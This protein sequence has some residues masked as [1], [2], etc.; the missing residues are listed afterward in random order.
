MPGSYTGFIGGLRGKLCCG[1]WGRCWGI[2]LRSCCC[3]WS[4]ISLC[5]WNILFIWACEEDCPGIWRNCCCCLCCCWRNSD[6]SECCWGSIF[7]WAML[8]I[9]WSCC[10]SNLTDDPRFLNIFCCCW[11]LET[12]PGSNLTG[13]TPPRTVGNCC[14]CCCCIECWACWKFWGSI[15]L[16]RCCSANNWLENWWPWTWPDELGETIEALKDDKP[17]NP[18]LD[19]GSD[20]APL[21]FTKE[22]LLRREEMFGAFP[23]ILILMLL[24][25]WGNAGCEGRGAPPVGTFSPL[26]TGFGASDGTILCICRKRRVTVWISI[27]SALCWSKGVSSAQWSRSVSNDKLQSRKTDEE[28]SWI[29]VVR[30][31]MEHSRA[32]GSRAELRNENPRSKWTKSAPFQLSTYNPKS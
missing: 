29:W 16:F 21:P 24:L 30:F 31:R 32:K 13:P 27:T 4:C 25:N 14:C 17:L 10:G 8:L 20:S 6:C 1:N 11:S 15:F 12:W 5:C 22:W 23:S 9:A 28:N 7:T 3:C 19:R 2:D 18:T 26:P